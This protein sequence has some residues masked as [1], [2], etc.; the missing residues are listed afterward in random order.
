VHSCNRFF[1]WSPL[2]P[3]I[4]TVTVT[5]SPIFRDLIAGLMT[6]YRNLDVVEKFDTR[7]RLEEQ[8]AAVAPDLIL[9]GLGK[10]EPDEI[11][12][13]LADSDEAARV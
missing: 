12:A 6:G 5:M 11:G 9:I 7:D 1:Q 4:R 8:L 3:A 2:V 13:P 10:N